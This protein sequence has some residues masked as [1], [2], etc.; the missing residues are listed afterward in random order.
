MISGK[1][2]TTSSLVTGLFDCKPILVNPSQDELSQYT[3]QN[4]PE[5]YVKDEYTTIAIWHE[6][7]FKNEKYYLPLNINLNN[8]EK[9]SSTGKKLF[10]NN[11]AQ[12]QWEF[13]EESIDERN[14]SLDKKEMYKYISLDGLRPAKGGELTLMYYLLAL[15]NFDTK[16]EDFSLDISTYWEDLIQ[17]KVEKLKEVV[18]SFDKIRMLVMID[19]QKERMSFFKKESPIGKSPFLPMG[20][21]LHKL[22][23]SN[24]GDKVKNHDFYQSLLDLDDQGHPGPYSMRN[25]FYFE[26]A[27]E[28]YSPSPTSISDIVASPSQAEAMDT[29]QLDDIF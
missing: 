24:S 14:K 17:G 9:L 27:P 12:V 29:S 1:K 7:E 5:S 26:L 28:E 19:E 18:F 6:F 10:I 15:S 25:R 4:V 8:E 22:N 2:N 23:V 20:Y 13:S 11:K 3:S 21:T 16:S